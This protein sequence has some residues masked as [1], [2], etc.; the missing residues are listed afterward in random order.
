MNKKNNDTESF[1]QMVNDLR[2]LNNVELSKQVR[3][4]RDNILNNL[5]SK[6]SELQ[7]EKGG[8]SNL[9]YI[10][11]AVCIF[12]LGIL[13]YSHRQNEVLE[14]KIQ[15]YQ[16]VDSLYKTFMEPTA[17][18]G[19]IKYEINTDGTAKSYR[20][21]SEEKDSLHQVLFNLQNRVYSLESDLYMSKIKLDLI[22]KNYP[23]KVVEDKNVI[24]VNALEIDSALMLL[25]RYRHKLQYD[26]IKKYWVIH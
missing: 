6:L 8:L 23:I 4:D 19:S 24:K 21:L 12:G 9:L 17:D 13:Y 15:Y 26:S 5:E 14:S 3:M 2:N 10:L 18:K 7:K 1:T 11:M 25:H 20:Q 16:R 22:E